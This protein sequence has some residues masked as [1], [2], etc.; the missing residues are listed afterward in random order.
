MDDRD[1]QAFAAIS[2]VRQNEI[3]L[4]DTTTSLSAIKIHIAYEK[5]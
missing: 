2:D 1:E 3:I 4:R 5:I